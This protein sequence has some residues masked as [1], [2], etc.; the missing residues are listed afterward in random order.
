MI[1]DGYPIPDDKPYRG[2]GGKPSKYPFAEMKPGQSVLYVGQE[3]GDKAHSYAM[4]MGPLYGAKFK[5]Q[6]MDGG[7]RIWRVV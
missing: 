5:T 1:E 2:F 3:N 7:L 6:K 4:R